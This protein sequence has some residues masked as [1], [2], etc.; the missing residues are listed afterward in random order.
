[1]CGITG[2]V[3]LLDAERLEAMTSSLAHRGPD[4]SGI[5]LFPAEGV[6][7]GHRRLSIIDLSPAGHEP[8]SNADES[9]WIKFNG[10]IYNYRE[11][12]QGLIE[13]GRTFR[14]NTDT[15]VILALYERD[16]VEAFKQ[17]N[18]IFALAILD[19]RRKKLL[20]ARD[21]LGVKPLYYLQA[22]EK[23]VFGS[24]I[25]A[26]LAS[27]IYSPEIN[28]QAFYDYFTYLYVSCP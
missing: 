6:G 17:L 2:T 24:E 11:L 21:H 15:E 7:L 23:F 22:G 10:E 4:D 25:K 16:G 3:N 13:Q 27:G 18:G 9:I 8:M 26:I 19:R 20:L 14:S 5:R 12:R 1:M 28:G